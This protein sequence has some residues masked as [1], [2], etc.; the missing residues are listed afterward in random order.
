MPTIVLGFLPGII[1]IITG[2][3]PLFLLSQFMILAGAGDFLIVARLLLHR[4]KNTQV[5]YLDHPYECGL[6]AFVKKND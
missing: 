5:I 6:V 4:P 1:A 2:W 3:E